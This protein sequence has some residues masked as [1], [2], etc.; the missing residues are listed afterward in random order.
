MIF[1]HS[2][3][4]TSATLEFFPQWREPHVPATIAKTQGCKAH[5]LE[6]DLFSPV[7]LITTRSLPPSPAP[8]FPHLL[9]KTV[10]LLPKVQFLAQNR[11]SA[12][13]AKEES[14]GASFGGSQF[15]ILESFW[16]EQNVQVQPGPKKQDFFKRE[17]GSSKM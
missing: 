3:G 5:T 8:L 14:W 7:I 15:C 9:N 16:N 13:A 10:T 12:K 17:R 2:T 4:K 1:S 11:L 6:P